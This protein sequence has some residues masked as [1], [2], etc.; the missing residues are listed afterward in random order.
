MFLRAASRPTI[1]HESVA[2]VTVHEHALERMFQRMRLMDPTAVQT[3]LHD[4]MCLSIP[5]Q[6]ACRRAGLR[7]I[8]LPTKSGAFLCSL[9][10]QKDSLLAKTWIPRSDD[11]SGKMRVVELVD[12]FYGSIGG[13][14]GFSK[15]LAELPEGAP[16]TGLV[17]LHG[18]EALAS[19]HP[20]LK[21]EYLSPVDP[22]DEAWKH[23]Q[24]EVR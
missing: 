16:L 23:H 15:M 19:T 22:L 6:I 11:L 9:N 5:L 10:E 18:V 7:Q 8:V 2:C 1:A 20:W 21:H 13:E 3:E 24:P 12:H 17:L 14:Q 4:A